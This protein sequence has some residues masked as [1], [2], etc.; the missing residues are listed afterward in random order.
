VERI[1]R[2]AG[3]AALVA[4]VLAAPAARAQSVTTTTTTVRAVPAPTPPPAP[5][6]QPT[7]L[8]E[9]TA[10]T[11]PRHTLKLGVLA[12]DYA[13]AEGAVVG[14]DPP[15]WAVRAFTSVLV[16]N[17]HVKVQVLRL[18]PVWV[19]LQAAGYY[20]DVSSNFSGQLLDVP[21]T[22]WVS[23]KLN[24]HFF[25]HAEGTYVYV[26]AFGTGDLSRS[27]LAGTAAS[28]SVQAQLMAQLQ[29][30][31]VVSFTALG[32]Y[33]IYTG[34]IAFS[35]SGTID[36]YTTA[37]V[38]GRLTLPVTHPWE[39]IG[40]VALLWKHFHAI[41]GAGYGYYFV[42]GMW[43]AS[44]TRSFIPDAELAVLF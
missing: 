20:A 21:L 36:P 43:I 12:F 28:Q 19:S 1:T 22:A 3:G 31:Q 38:Q 44:Q 27:E 9:K 4:L 2:Y 18:D 7:R 11:I 10:F 33:Q 15:A 26:H 24:D 23:F 32:R 39:A 17:L 16:P 40:G 35:G 42:P 41:L 25:L 8:D 37:D 6:E 13:F 5:P 30:S 14:S 29:L 34:D